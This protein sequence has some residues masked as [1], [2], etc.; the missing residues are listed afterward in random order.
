MGRSF[1]HPSTAS[2]CQPL[3]RLLQP[4][5]YH[6]QNGGIRAKNVA[7]VDGSSKLIRAEIFDSLL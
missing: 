1:I 4:M 6:V 2:T 5:K 7:A 3:Y